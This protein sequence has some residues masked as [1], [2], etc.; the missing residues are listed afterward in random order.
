M[1]IDWKY[2]STTPGYKSLKKAYVDDLIK[3]TRSKK[4]LLE[5]FNWV[6]CRAKHYSYYLSKPIEEVLNDWESKRTYWWLNYYQPCKQHKLSP[7]PVKPLGI[8]GFRKYYKKNYSDQ[9][10]KDLICTKICKIQKENS[11]KSP[12][13]W[14]TEK[15]KYQKRICKKNA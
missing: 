3:N 7:N 15:K 10:A 14:S 9:T 1:Q 5:L 13:R 8:N 4:E 2:L 6:I 12:N 11:T